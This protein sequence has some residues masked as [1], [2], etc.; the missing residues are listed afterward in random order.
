MNSEA[1]RPRIALRRRVAAGVLVCAVMASAALLSAQFGRGRVGIRMVPREL[2][3]RSFTICRIM[4]ESVR[5]EASG[6]GWQTDYPY[7][8][9]NL[10]IRFS[11]L[12]RAPVSKDPGQRPNHYVV[13]LTDD[14]LFSCPYTVASDVG[15]MGLRDVE[16]LKLREYLLKGGF[17]WVDDFW[18]TPA[19]EHWSSVIREVLP[20]RPIEDVSLD[21]PIFRTQF[22]VKK[23]PQVP[24]YPFWVATGGQ[25]SERGDDSREAH[26]RAIRD[27][28]GRIMVV[29][30]HNTDVADSWER[31]GE[32]PE[33]FQKF[34]IDGYALGVDVLLYA[35][36][37]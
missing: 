15:T 10:M 8:D 18:G 24:R 36:T 27:D 33:Y 29:M 7:G 32:E 28:K 1:S 13:R 17:L 37:H 19:W 25:T 6:A 21:D 4:Y 30:T 26:F 31:E 22:V 3:D 23:V 16:V 34:S 35:L 9:N 2:P 11:E 20:G 14:A 12:T 5:S